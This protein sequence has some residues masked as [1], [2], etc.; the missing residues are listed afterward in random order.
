MKESKAGGWSEARISQRLL[1]FLAVTA[2]AAAT[3][4]S[5]SAAAFDFTP[6][7]TLSDMSAFFPHVV[8]DSR[9][10]ATVV[11]EATSADGEFVL[12]QAVR[13]VSGVPT[14]PVQTLWSAP[15]VIYPEWCPCPRLAI[16]PQDRV[17]VVWQ[18]FDGTSLG[19]QAVRLGTDGLPLGPVQTLSKSGE[20]AFDHRLA[21]DS[22]GVATVGWT[23]SG[24]INRVESTRLQPSGVHDLPKTLSE[25]GVNSSMRD[26]AID[27]EGRA[28]V[29]WDSELGVQSMRLGS[30]GAA[31]AV[32]T[33]S[34]EDAGAPR[35]VVDSQNRATVAWW[36]GSGIYDVQAVRLAA[37]GTPGPIRTLSPESQETLDPVI[38]IDGHDRVTVAWEE[39]AGR[40]VNAVRLGADGVPGPVHLLSD[41][42]RVA[43]QPQL[44]TAPGGMTVVVWAHPV[45]GSIFPGSGECIEGP[46]FEPESDVVQAAFIGPD[47]VPGPVYPVS[48][49]GEQSTGPAVA[50]DSRG[51][52]TVAWTSFDGTYFCFSVEP[53]IQSSWGGE[54]IEPPSAGAPPPEGVSAPGTLR[55]G[56]RAFVRGGRIVI[57]GRCV[58]DRGVTCNGRLRLVARAFGDAPPRRDD[59]GRELRR[60][61]ARAVT[62]ARK[63]FRLAAG[64]RCVLALRLSRPGQSLVL[65]RLDR[66]IRAKAEGPGVSRRIVS[67]SAAWRPS[68][69]PWRTSRAAISSQGSASNQLPGGE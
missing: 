42:D 10:R 60:T 67:I 7:R 13:L 63:R 1:L 30:D 22:G 9:D 50:V 21:V 44:A 61:S 17:T 3:Q 43:G 20:D 40:G 18:N 52:P 34:D 69:Y 51:R 19:V 8:V 38:A 56:K 26:L 11:W 64:K 39:F 49:L 23:V 68:K 65:G 25:T 2:A 46:S 35:V 29:V 54:V 6:P 58:G 59:R 66:D 14:G 57:R 48:R 24:P 28:T 12:I 5:R 55:L 33:L 62:L 31:G 41:P 37:D 15:N 4:P 27:R 32:Q 47:G 45:V 53:R 16:D 36:R